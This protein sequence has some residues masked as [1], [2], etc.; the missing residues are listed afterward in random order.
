MHTILQY[1]SLNMQSVLLVWGDYVQNVLL[2]KKISIRR[3]S[4]RP[5]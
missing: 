4:I 3:L 5:P 2:D 1:F